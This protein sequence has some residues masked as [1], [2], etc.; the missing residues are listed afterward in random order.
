MRVS[1]R[2]ADFDALTIL[3]NTVA[4]KEFELD[5]ATLRRQIVGSPLLDWGASSIE[6][7]DGEPLALV[8]IKRS[9]AGL[10]GGDPDVAHISAFACHECQYGVDLMAQAKQMLRQRG[11]YKLVFGMDSQHFFP[12]CPDIWPMLHDFLTVEGFEE[13]G[14]Y[15]DLTHD[16]RNFQSRC[17]L[18]EQV[19]PV[20]HATVPL[21]MDFLEREFPGRWMYDTQMKLEAE[22][23][24]SFI[25]GLFLHGRCEGFAVTQNSDSKLPINGAVFSKSLG[26]NWC[27]LGP[28]G[29]SKSI[30]GSGWGDKLLAGALHDMKQRGKALCRIDW[31]G[32]A[33]WYGKHGFKIERKYRSMTLRLD[34]AYAP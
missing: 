8:A 29:V 17:E 33:D 6:V 20:E 3:W 14:E 11:V 34:Q 19:L 12:G 5:S 28:I 31:T 21:L 10:Y 4:P 23:S 30:R 2:N 32:L 13:G 1:F 9:A 26:E 25:Y 16:L 18:S 24:P 15:Y 22:E 7:V 27:A